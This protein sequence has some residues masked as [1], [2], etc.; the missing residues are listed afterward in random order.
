MG[1][2]L[3]AMYVN[4]DAGCLDDRVVSTPI[5]SRLAPTFWNQAHPQKTGR[6]SGRLAALL[7]CSPPRKAGARH[8][9]KGARALGYA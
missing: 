1:A 9:T 8:R 7:R 2:S 5:A 4:D 3:L 6:L